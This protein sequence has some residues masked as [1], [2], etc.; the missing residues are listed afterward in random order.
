MHGVKNLGTASRQPRL[1]PLAPRSA[2]IANLSSL[3][4]VEHRP[5]S[6]RLTPSVLFKMEASGAQVGVWMALA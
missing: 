4:P 5:R 1:T 2:L 3:A 6:R